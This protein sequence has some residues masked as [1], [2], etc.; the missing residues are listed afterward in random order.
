MPVDF[1]WD[2]LSPLSFPFNWDDLFPMSMPDFDWELPMSYPTDAAADVQLDHATAQAEALEHAVAAAEAAEAEAAA[3]AAAAEAAQQA[4]AADLAA[5]EQAEA[6]V[7]AVDL[8]VT[9]E[10]VQTVCAFHMSARGR[11]LQEASGVN[12]A[13]CQALTDAVAAQA[14]TDESVV[15]SCA[16]A[17]DGTITVTVTFFVQDAAAFDES[18]EVDPASVVAAAQE[19][20]AIPEETKAQLAQASVIVEQVQVEN[21]AAELEAAVD[22]VAEEK[23]RAAQ[24]KADADAAAAAAAEAQAVA[25]QQRQEAARAAEAAAQRVAQMEQL[26]ANDV[27]TDTATVTV[28][29]D[30]TFQ[31]QPETTTAPV[32]DDSQEEP[33]PDAL[34]TTEEAQQET[35]EEAQQ[36]TDGPD[37]ILTESVSEYEQTVIK[38]ASTAAVEATLALAAAVACAAVGV[39]LA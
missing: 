30:D 34:A 27:P 9:P 5:A 13:M 29:A 28:A 4:A 8:S 38:K 2:D 36:E 17:G 21:P 12:P 10:A 11:K 31:P 6:A 25:E 39:R 1:G 16:D 19:S 32:Q 15:G 33:S 14:G 23:A 37:V 7:H 24:A 22:A 3:A 26:I 18:F 20:D 35:T